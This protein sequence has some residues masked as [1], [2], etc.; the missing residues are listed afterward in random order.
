MIVDEVFKILCKTYISA[1]DGF[2][3]AS[4]NYPATR[5]VII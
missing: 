5:K 1:K 2:A 4:S 3:K